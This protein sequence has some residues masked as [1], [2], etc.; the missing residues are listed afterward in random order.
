VAGHDIVAEH[1]IQRHTAGRRLIKRLP[2]HSFRKGKR[3]R[4]GRRK[5]KREEKKEKGESIRII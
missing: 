5:G 1:E 2:R 4:K 3:K